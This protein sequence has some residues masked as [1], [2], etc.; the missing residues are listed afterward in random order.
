VPKA[1]LTRFLAYGEK[2]P[3]GKYH[4]TISFRMEESLASN[5]IAEKSEKQI[6]FVLGVYKFEFTD[7]MYCIFQQMLNSKLQ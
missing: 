3:G 6:Q 4:A 5:L 7:K 2:K 1:T